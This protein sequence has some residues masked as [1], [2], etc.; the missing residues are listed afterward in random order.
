MIYEEREAVVFDGLKYIRSLDWPREE[1]YD[2]ERD[3]GEKNNI[4]FLR[5]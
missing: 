3:P 1:L 5:R 2:L 4:A